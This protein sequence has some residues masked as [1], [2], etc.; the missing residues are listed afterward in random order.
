MEDAIAETSGTAA[1]AGQASGM[2]QLDFTTF[3]NQIFWL[4]VALVVIHL[5]LTRVALPRI[6]GVLAE[7]S[8]SIGNDL[9]RAEELQAQAV[10]AE[11]AY[12]QALA[13]ARA[14][15]G[16]IAEGARAEIQTELSAEME[17]AEATI[18]ARTAESEKAIGAIRDEAMATVATVARETAHEIVAA[19]GVKA[20]A[21]AIDAAV[22]SRVKGGES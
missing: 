5:I 1:Q 19:F 16:R 22:D 9:A 10:E 4:V 13:D 18:A 8:G 12:E 11:L 15:A 7:R 6:G 2:P 17:K 21:E 20:E 3:G 14:E